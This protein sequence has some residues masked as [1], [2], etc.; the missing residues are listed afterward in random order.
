MLPAAP[1][2]R[3]HGRSLQLRKPMGHYDGSSVL[4]TICI[5]LCRL[6][7]APTLQSTLPPHQRGIRTEKF[8]LGISLRAHWLQPANLSNGPC[9]ECKDELDRFWQSSSV[10][11]PRLQRCWQTLCQ[12]IWLKNRRHSARGG[13][14]LLEGMHNMQEKLE[15]ECDVS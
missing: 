11:R 9:Q 7:L 6:C 5:F 1:E 12:K 8:H 10:R 14:R 4:R 2:M 15:E 13:H 3:L